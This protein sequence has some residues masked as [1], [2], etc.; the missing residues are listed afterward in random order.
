MLSDESGFPEQQGIFWL[1]FRRNIHPD[2]YMEYELKRGKMAV[3]G[4]VE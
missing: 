3:Q 2:Y 1:I 4:T